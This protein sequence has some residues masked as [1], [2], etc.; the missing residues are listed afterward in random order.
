MESLLVF[1]LCDGNFLHQF[2]LESFGLIH[3]HFKLSTLSDELSQHLVCFLTLHF[4]FCF[5][6]IQLG[7]DHFLSLFLHRELI[8]GFT[9]SVCSL[10]QLIQTALVSFRNFVHHGQTV[11]QVGE[12]VCLENNCPVG[13]AALFLHGADAFLILAAQLIKALLG[14]VQFVLLV[15]NQQI[16]G[17][18]LVVAVADLGIDDAD[19]LVDQILLVD[20]LHHFIF[21]CFVLGLQLFQFFL[22]LFLLS[23]H[24][25]DLLLDLAGR[26]C[27]Y[28]G[29]HHA[30]HSRQHQKQRQHR[31][32]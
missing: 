11:Q 30:E 9:D 29:G 21:I 5:R 15:C 17:C 20:Q 22:K 32:Q 28:I 14:V 31:G 19:L 23:I 26:G 27:F 4:Q 24:L 3:E 8:L 25:I 18:D 13:N 1:C 12:T 7:A 6:G 2:I 16:E 10:A